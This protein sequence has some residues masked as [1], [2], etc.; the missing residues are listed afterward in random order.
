M[1]STWVRALL[2]S[3]VLF[4]VPSSASATSIYFNTPSPALFT[5]T[6]ET[7]PLSGGGWVVDDWD[8]GVA[9]T[10]AQIQYV[11]ANLQAMYILIEWRTGP[12]DT[13]VDNI[14]FG[15][16]ASET[17]GSGLGGWY[18]AGPDPDSDIAGQSFGTG[19]P[20]WDASFGQP[21][22]SLR[23]QDGFFWH[24]IAAPSAFLGN[25]SARYG[26]TLSFD[27]FIRHTDG[28]PY[29]AVALVAPDPVPEPAT[30]M[31]LG[32]GLVGLFCARRR[33]SLRRRG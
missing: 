2:V 14:F 27:I 18:T 12:D 19:V 6:T 16:G 29:P 22:G 1:T 33:G 23:D 24:W 5:W 10:Q 30:M 11:L 4:A 21:A 28:V 31:L 7:I 32:G 15:T 20:S 26:E 3:A 8:G 13:N 25:Q 17:F 9:A